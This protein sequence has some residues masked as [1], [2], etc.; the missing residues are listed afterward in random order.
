MIHYVEWERP[1]QVVSFRV[2]IF[3]IW[4]EYE[5]RR[6]GGGWDA[7]RILGFVFENLVKVI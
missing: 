2:W 3:H 1:S 4:N 5:P 7:I 6:S